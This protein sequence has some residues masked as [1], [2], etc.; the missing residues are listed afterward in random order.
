MPALGK[1][2]ELKEGEMLHLN[3]PNYFLNYIKPLIPFDN[4]KK[5]KHVYT[6]ELHR[7]KYTEELKVLS[8]KYEKAVHKKDRDD[9]FV[10]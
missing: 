6:I 2:E 5:P 1:T 8:L 4:T 10:Q 9:Q 3:D 7:C